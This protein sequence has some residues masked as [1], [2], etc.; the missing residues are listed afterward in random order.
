MDTNTIVSLCKTSFTLS[1]NLTEMVHVS[2]ERLHRLTKMSEFFVLNSI[3][4]RWEQEWL[5]AFS[6]QWHCRA[7]LQQPSSKLGGL[8]QNPNRRWEQEPILALGVTLTSSFIYSKYP[9]L[10]QSWSTDSLFS[11]LPLHYPSLPQT[12]VVCFSSLTSPL[13]HPPPIEQQASSAFL[14]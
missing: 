10:V 9:C 7:N 14:S 1:I 4:I 5:R 8:F 2:T 11:L 3:P 13:L 12:F 6:A